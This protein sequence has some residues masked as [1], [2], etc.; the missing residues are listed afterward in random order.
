MLS[1]GNEG[2]GFCG[3][4]GVDD[5]EGAVTQQMTPVRQTVAEVV[6]DLREARRGKRKLQLAQIIDLERLEPI[7][8]APATMARLG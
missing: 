4:Y 7:E 6:A 2:S 3:A 1:D 5:N 8:P